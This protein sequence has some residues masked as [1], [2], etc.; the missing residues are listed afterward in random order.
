M[1]DTLS[2]FGFASYIP[3]QFSEVIC[4][5]AKN[6]GCWSVVDSVSVDRCNRQC[7][8][9]HDFV[10]KKIFDYFIILIIVC[11]HCNG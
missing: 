8:L 7:H 5:A 9:I 11:M 2:S 10:G 6:I 3:T 1:K 4:N